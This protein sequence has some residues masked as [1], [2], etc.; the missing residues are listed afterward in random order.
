M[1]RGTHPM[2][3]GGRL[4]VLRYMMPTG[5]LL[6]LSTVVRHTVSSDTR[7]SVADQIFIW[8][9]GASH[10]HQASPLLQHRPAD[11]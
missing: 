3:R 1:Q 8:W 6:D 5:P 11:E 2:P 4:A 9:C 7:C 10:L